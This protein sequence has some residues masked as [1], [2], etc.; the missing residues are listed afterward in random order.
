M[1]KPEFPYKYSQAII[2]SDR[3]M[4]YAK[5]EGVLLL[6]KGTIG[7]STPGT[8][9]LDAK[10]KV[11]VFS[12]KI[13]LGSK[14]TEQVILGNSMVK[15]LKDIMTSVKNLSDSLS[16]INI[17]NFAKTVPN[18]R[19]YADLLSKTLNDKLISIENNL[20]K[21]TYTE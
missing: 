13:E 1:I 3:V 12:P 21:V 8:I 19:F 18:I 7:L 14:A 6:G 4:L 9:N 17:T 11:L 16:K 15:D 10:E 2:T 5:K 20:S